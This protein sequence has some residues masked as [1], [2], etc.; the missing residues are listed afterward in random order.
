MD[1]GW[2]VVNTLSGH[3][4]KVK[5]N[6]EKKVKNKHLEEKIFQVKVPTV[7]VTEVKG[8][9]KRTRKKKYLPGYVMIEMIG[10]EEA[11]FEVMSVPGVAKFIGSGDEP[12]PLSAQEVETLFQQMGEGAAQEKLA[13]QHLFDIGEQV[14]VIDGP[15]NNFH[16]VVEEVN[17]EKGRLRIRVEIFGRST[18]VELNFTQV[19]KI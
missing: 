3:E 16:G 8:G 6:L 11:I 1:K 14:K 2:Y 10:D 19:G 12:K 4:D 15:F 7:D 13:A 5:L 18:P 9:K 17:L